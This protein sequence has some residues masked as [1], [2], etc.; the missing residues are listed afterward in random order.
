MGKLGVVQCSIQMQAILQS[1]ACCS[2]C[3][4][5]FSQWW[6]IPAS[7]TV[8]LQCL[9]NDSTADTPPLP[10]WGVTSIPNVLGKRFP[11]VFYMRNSYLQKRT[12]RL[13]YN[14]DA[15]KTL[16]W[17][18]NVQY[19]IKLLPYNDFKPFSCFAGSTKTFIN[20]RSSQYVLLVPRSASPLRYLS[21]SVEINTTYSIPRQIYPMMKCRSA[22]A[23][24]TCLVVYVPSAFHLYSSNPVHWTLTHIMCLQILDSFFFY[25]LLKFVALS[26]SQK[27]V[28]LRS[29]NNN[30]K[31]SYF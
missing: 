29:V 12:V 1:G 8:M 15:F 24:I 19:E 17:F 27:S 10:L 22:T 31:V 25:L 9:P 3:S 16:M 20:T 13:V 30:N 4:F 21:S 28:L 14:C 6:Q 11:T 5:L 23:L 18:F 26:S 2:R 7:Q